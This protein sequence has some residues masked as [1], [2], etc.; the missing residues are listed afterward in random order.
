MGIYKELIKEKFIQ[1]RKSFLD[2][3]DTSKFGWIKKVQDEWNVS[4]TQVKRW[5][6]KY[7]KSG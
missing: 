3:I 6:K 4:H 5:I 7:S 2:S 1:L